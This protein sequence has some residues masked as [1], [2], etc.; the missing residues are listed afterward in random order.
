MAYAHSGRVL[1][2]AA[3]KGA[4][5]LWRLDRASAGL[6]GRTTV[7]FEFYRGMEG[8]LSFERNDTILLASD[9]L[10]AAAAIPLPGG[11]APLRGQV[12]HNHPTPDDVEGDR[13]TPYA[14]HPHRPILVTAGDDHN[15]S[16]WSIG[17]TSLLR[18]TEPLRG[19]DR[20]IL[21]LAFSPSGK[22]LATAGYDRIVR[23]WPVDPPQWV[24]IPATLSS[25]PADLIL[26]DGVPNPG[27][28]VLLARFILGDEW[29]ESYHDGSEFR[30]NERTGSAEASTVT[31]VRRRLARPR[32]ERSCAAGVGFG[33]S[34]PSS[35]V[36]RGSAQ[37]RVTP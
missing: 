1:A 30:L 16:V 12:L 36:D 37:E 19:H 11:R 13:A 18:R 8:Q 32:H 15:V 24:A 25:N 21:A 33:L 7:P 26:N 29:L 2:V 20:E 28:G 34:T 31:I 27:G 22:W 3:K 35:S 5:D 4:I 6:I 17:E 23:L 9:G 10:R 14:V